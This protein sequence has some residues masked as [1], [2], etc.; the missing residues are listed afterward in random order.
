MELTGAHG[1][2]GLPLCETAGRRSDPGGS[3]YGR[4]GTQAPALSAS[5]PV[6][7]PPAPR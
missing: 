3:A 2:T 5:I 7:S 4:S 1:T 6:I